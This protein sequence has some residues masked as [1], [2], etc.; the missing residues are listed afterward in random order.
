MLLPPFAR[1]LLVDH[2][3]TNLVHRAGSNQDGTDREGG[4]DRL[5]S[6]VSQERGMPTTGQT[7][8]S[9]SMSS[10]FAKEQIVTGQRIRRRQKKSA[11]SPRSRAHPLGVSTAISIQG[12]IETARTTLLGTP[13]RLV[14]KKGRKKKG[15]AAVDADQTPSTSVDQHLKDLL[16]VTRWP[17]VGPHRLSRMGGAHCD[18]RVW[19][20]GWTKMMSKRAG[21]SIHTHWL[22]DDEAPGSWWMWLMR[23][24]GVP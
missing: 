9:S 10:Q 8:L 17:V 22:D 16:F 2:P 18:K 21:V 19:R 6:P 11:A 14:P 13:T 15:G 1:F 5:H 7:A 3:I 24:R 20:G 12:A 4:Q 23:W